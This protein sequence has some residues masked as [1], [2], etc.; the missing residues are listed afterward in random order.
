MIQPIQAIEICS[1]WPVLAT[2]ILNMIEK[3]VIVQPAGSNAWNR[4]ERAV[5]MES[6][7]GAK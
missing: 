7:C 3:G 1:S 5:M 6:E 4:L 2:K